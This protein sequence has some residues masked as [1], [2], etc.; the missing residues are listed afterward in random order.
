MSS[1]LVSRF[2]RR[3]GRIDLE[4]LTALLIRPS[5]LLVAGT[6]PLPLPPSSIGPQQIEVPQPKLLAGWCVSVTPEHLILAQARDVAS[7]SE[8]DDSCAPAL[9]VKKTP[10]DS[11]FSE[12]ELVRRA[13][14]EV[15]MRNIN[16]FVPTGDILHTADVKL[17]Y[18]PLYQ[19]PAVYLVS[20]HGRHY[21]EGNPQI[22]QVRTWWHPASKTT[23][24]P[25]PLRKKEKPPLSPPPPPPPPPKPSMTF[26]T[27]DG[28][29]KIPKVVE[30]RSG[31]KRESLEVEERRTES[32]SKQPPVKDSHVRESLQLQEAEAKAVVD[33][34]ADADLF[35]DSDVYS[36]VKVYSGEQTL[37]VGRSSPGGAPR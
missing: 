7:L 3:G 34:D 18:C 4:L 23:L 8:S 33:A 32:R 29:L 17:E 25:P 11:F 14:S 22:V 15:E 20:L 9:V 35:A 27:E 26:K 24:P 37:A 36:D 2:K 6:A 19:A 31:R 16:A 1:R 12:E 21:D 30:I 10:G 28:F 5:S 13:S